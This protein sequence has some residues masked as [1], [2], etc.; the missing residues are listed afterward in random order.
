[1][2]IRTCVPTPSV[3]PKQLPTRRWLGY[4]IGT[5]M[6]VVCVLGFTADGAVAQPSTE[7][8]LRVGIVQRFG[9][10]PDDELTLEATTGDRLTLR[11]LGGDMQPKTL[12]VPS[13]KLQIM[14]RPL[15]APQPEE[16]VV[17]SN[18]PNFE[19]AEHSAERWRALGIKVE[20]AQPQRWEVWAKRDVYSTPLLRRLLLQS[21]E[22]QGVKTAYVETT[23]LQQAPQA[24]WEVNGFRYNR[25]QLE[26]TAGQ[27]VIQVAQGKDRKPTRSYVGPMKLQRNAYGSY[28]L[29]NTVPVETYLRGVVPNEIGA[30]A[31]FAALE[32]QAILARTYALRNLRRFTID[33]YELCADVHCQVYFGLSGATPTTDRAIAATKGLVMTYNNELADA[34]YS[35][36]TGGVTA[37][38]SDVWNGADRPYLRPVLDAVTNLWDLSRYSLADEQNFRRF[39]SL[40]QGFNEQ[41]RNL[42]RW[43]RV[44]SLPDMVTHLQRYLGN[45]K[46]P[47]AGFQAIKDIRVIERSP[48]GRIQKMVVETDLGMVELEKEEV[49][50][51]FY[52]PRST[53]F[54][55]EPIEQNGSIWGYAFVGGGFGHGVGLSQTGAIQLANQGWSSRRIL[56]FYY[57]G[58]QVQPLTD[59]IVLWRDRSRI[60]K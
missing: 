3:M 20:I 26:I 46:H 48:A 57:P 11:F 7:R 56:N 18:H 24:F 30:S 4:W 51:A 40:D 55:I 41:G 25:D 9:A 49:R 53:L 58:T 16:R 34:L 29:V 44:S 32:A 36:T 39:I 60:K 5:V 10:K 52:P 50:S 37:A 54:Y 35:A 59:G 19:M 17:L 14:M 23:I 15:S 38:F 2:Q 33:N 8:Q 12:T 28:T 6:T 22:A 27:N 31:P 43:R 13:V 21:L 1:M 47:L 45:R 42:F